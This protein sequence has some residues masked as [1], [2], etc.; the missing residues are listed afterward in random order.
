M[1]SLGGLLFSAVSGPDAPFA[2][3][4]VVTAGGTQIKVWD[5]FGGG[6]ELACLSNHQKTVT[7]IAVSPHA[8]PD[9]AAAPRLL[10]GALDGHLKASTTVGGGYEG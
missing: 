9:S 7:C 5:L 10:T 6:R 1:S 2:G 3:S 4:L 8:G